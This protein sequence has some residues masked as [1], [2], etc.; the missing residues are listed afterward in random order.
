MGISSHIFT[1]ITL[2]FHVQISQKSLAVWRFSFHNLSCEA[3]FIPVFRTPHS[4]FAPFLLPVTWSASHPSFSSI[5]SIYTLPALFIPSQS[6]PFRDKFVEVD[7]KPVCKHCYE[8]L[9]E[10]MKRRLARRDRDSKDKKKKLL[11]PMCL[12]SC[13]SPFSS[14]AVFPLW[15]VSFLL[16]PTVHFVDFYICGVNDSRSTWLPE[17]AVKVEAVCL[18]SSGWSREGKAFLSSDSS[19]FVLVLLGKTRGSGSL[20]LLLELKAW[21]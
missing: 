18:A 14:P 10:D 16:F 2:S 5:F 12:W 4:P 17:Y 15:S 13:L 6:S 21:M 20:L 1:H 7:L 11:I 9:P 3:I 19:V 8:R